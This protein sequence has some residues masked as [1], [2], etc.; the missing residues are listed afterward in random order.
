MSSRKRHTAA[1]D[2]MRQ[3]IAA[4]RR[5]ASFPYGP[6]WDRMVAKL[7]KRGWIARERT[8]G[9]RFGWKPNMQRRNY[10]VSTRKGRRAVYAADRHAEPSLRRHSWNYSY[11]P[12]HLPSQMEADA[13]H[14]RKRAGVSRRIRDLHGSRPR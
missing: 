10:L 1:L 14:D 2:F 11:A 13:R 3:F 9:Y 8:E 5:I 12:H 6:G 4:E 7:M